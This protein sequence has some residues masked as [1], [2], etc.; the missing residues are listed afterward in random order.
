MRALAI[1]IMSVCLAV[2]LL[3]PHTTGPNEVGVR[4]VK[5]SAFGKKWNGLRG[6]KSSCEAMAR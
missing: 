3:Y 2:F 5:W 1:V 4:T 6:R